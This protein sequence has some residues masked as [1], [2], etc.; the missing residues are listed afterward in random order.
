MKI[1]GVIVNY[2]TAELA[3]E[4][5]RSLVADLEGLAGE[6]EV[7]DND[8]QDGS[9]ERL[10]Q[11]VSERGW[12]SLV[13]VTASGKN[14]GFGC[15]NNLAI[16]RAMRSESPPEYFFLL[17]PDA[18]VRAGTTRALV[19]F[20]DTRPDVGIAGTRLFLMNGEP[21]ISAFRFPSVLSEF[22]S[23]V[24]VGLVTRA[25]GRWVVAQ[26]L[27]D[28]TCEVDWVSGSSMMVRRSA[29]ESA[30]LFDED[31]FLYYEEIDLCRRV[32]DAGQKVFYVHDTGVDHV[33]RASTG[34]AFDRRLPAYWFDSRRHYYRK[35]HG[36]AYFVAANL[37]WSAGASI[38]RV[39]R[40]IV[41]G[42]RPDRPHML[43]DMLGHTITS[44]LSRSR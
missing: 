18:T 9:F 25:F 3:I 14:G 5:V 23:G 38:D 6:I 4:A 31:F 15:G 33:E 40:A 32:R 43:R 42:A 30:G 39:R 20:L 2:R 24:R 16:A 27:P 7:V 19:S 28:R 17:N 41:G 35:N 8:S 21:S 22:E 13:R 36:T 1:L 44:L 10:T 34:L 11:A 26:P 37:A 29:F 12:S